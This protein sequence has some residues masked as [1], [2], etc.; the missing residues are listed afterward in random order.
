VPPRAARAAPNPRA[1]ASRRQE[2][3][4]AATLGL[5]NKEVRKT[6]R[7]LEEDQL[8]LRGAV[9][10]RAKDSAAV[11]RAEGSEAPPPPSARTYNV[12]TCRLARA[13]AVPP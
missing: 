7:Y 4:L 13:A 8:V 11:A 6:L 12:R 5:S 1:R 10:E 3:D 2:E 9:R